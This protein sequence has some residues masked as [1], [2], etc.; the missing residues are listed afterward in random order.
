MTDS[1]IPYSF[2]PGTKAKAGEVNANFIALADAIESNRQAAAADIEELNETL[3]TK[4]SQT[5]LINEHTVT[6]SGTDLNNYKTKGTYI[7]SSL[8]TPS[9]IPKGNAGVLIVTGLN[10]SVIKQIWFCKGEN[11]EIF[12][13]EF[14]NSQWSSWYSHCG[15]T[16]FTNP[17]YYRLPNGLLVQWGY[18]VNPNV[19]FP[20]AYSTLSCPV[21][22]KVGCDFKRE[23]S[24][25]G[26]EQ[27]TLTGLLVYSGGI[28]YSIDYIVIGY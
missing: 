23:R 24:D 22:G 26:F 13:R 14:E 5:D 21:F 15:I 20:I 1:M 25:T 12:T 3:E 2:I 17:G 16:A 6:D 28:M 4:A 9:N 27:L 19:T 11:P 18:G 10:D 7:F 8:Y